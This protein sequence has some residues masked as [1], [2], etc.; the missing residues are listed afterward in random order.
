MR[1]RRRRGPGWSSRDPSRPRSITPS[2]EADYTLLATIYACEGLWPEEVS[3]LLGFNP[4][5]AA[6]LASS[7]ARPAR[8]VSARDVGAPE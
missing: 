1:T 3:S 2:N 8:A 5:R 7:N 6:R 4:D